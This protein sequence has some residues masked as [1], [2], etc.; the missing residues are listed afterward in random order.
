MKHAPL[1]LLLL[2]VFGLA[3]KEKIPNGPKRGKVMKAFLSTKDGRI[4]YVQWNHYDDRYEIK[5]IDLNSF[6]Q[7]MA[8]QI[9][10]TVNLTN[11]FDEVIDGTKEIKIRVK[12]WQPDANWVRHLS[13][14]EVNLSD[15][16]LLQPGHTRNFYTADSLMWDQRDDSGQLIFPVGH[17]KEYLVQEVR[18]DSLVPDTVNGKPGYKIKIWADCDTLAVFN[19]DSVVAF[20]K[21]VTILATASVKLFH[22]YHP[23]QSDTLKLQIRYFFPASYLERKLGCYPGFRESGGG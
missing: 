22:E 4:N 20:K 2:L 18:R 3:C 14:T 9:P 7:M 11:T 15:S 1:I 10:F 19:R 21:P 8:W 5:N 13:Y 16:V 17:Y 23:E 6:S 12:I